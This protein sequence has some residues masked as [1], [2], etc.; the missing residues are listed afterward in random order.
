[1]RKI[2][3]VSLSVLGMLVAGAIGAASA[4]AAG[5]EEAGGEKYLWKVGAE[6]LK[7][8]ELSAFVVT[9]GAT[10]KIK[11]KVGGE[12]VELVSP[13]RSQNRIRQRRRIQ[14]TNQCRW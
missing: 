9:T 11:G 13:K 6:K 10:F 12:E 4:A 14:E 2:V 3:V 1:M 7:A 5:C 8:G